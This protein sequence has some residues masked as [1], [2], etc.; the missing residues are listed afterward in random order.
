MFVSYAQNFEDVLLWRALKDVKDGFYIDVGAQDPVTDSVSFA[1]YERGWRGLHVEPVPMYAEKLRAS[2]PEEEVVQAAVSCE[3]GALPFFEVTATGLSTGKEAVA[4]RHSEGGLDVNELQVRSVRLSTLLDQYID[5]DIHWLKI[6][7]EE[8]ERE[9]ITS[10][11]PSTV[12]PWIVVVESTRARSPELNYLEWE[13]E[14]LALGYEFAYF[15]GLNRFYVHSDRSHLK[16]LLEVGPNVFDDFVVGKS[17]PFA[18]KLNADIA[19]LERREAEEMAKVEEL[20]KAVQ[21]MAERETAAASLVRAAE[22]WQTTCSALSSELI[23]KNETIASLREQLE[24]S[25][26]KISEL[27]ASNRDLVSTLDAQA[28]SLSTRSDEID[29]RDAQIAYLN[30]IVKEVSLRVSELDR[31][32]GSIHASTSWRFTAP[33]RAAMKGRRSLQSRLR[34]HSRDLLNRSIG[35][36]AEKP[37][38]KFVAKSVIRMLPP[39]DRRVRAV[40]LSR[41]YITAAVPSVHGQ[42]K[43][44]PD[45]VVLD[46]WEALLGASWK[47]RN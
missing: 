22:T 24:K 14:I 26:Q 40:A 5:K 43:M 27:E 29:N 4:K 28:A 38:I 35:W 37:Q 20:A 16:S 45:P 46:D 31:H 2:R 30:E 6:D 11:S 10:W 19:E 21:A 32:I 34:E 36:T 15:D 33:L 8:M 25:N 39:L 1:F 18:W 17:T 47:K 44:E 41:G 12:R 42:W 9:V 23:G 13:A 3:E 7:V